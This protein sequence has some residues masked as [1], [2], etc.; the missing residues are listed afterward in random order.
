LPV[1][2]SGS[3]ERGPVAVHGFIVDI[4][5]EPRPRPHVAPPEQGV[6]ATR[7]RRR[8]GFTRSDG[9][10]GDHRDRPR[11]PP[12]PTPTGATSNRLT[13]NDRGGST[14]RSRR[15]DGHRSRRRTHAGEPGWLRVRESVWPEE[16]VCGGHT[17]RIGGQTMG[18]GRARCSR[19]RGRLD[20]PRCRQPRKPHKPPTR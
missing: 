1:P 19:A 3:R 15:R 17:G 12:D 4:K 8:D 11:L 18:P 16:N 5:P 13:G 6:W 9:R 7:P 14:D 10:S 2:T 20:G